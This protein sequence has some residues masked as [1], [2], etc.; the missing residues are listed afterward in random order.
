MA[1]LGFD[2]DIRRAGT[3]MRSGAPWPAPALLR[4][5]HRGPLF[6]AARGTLLT[7]IP[8][9]RAHVRRVHRV[10]AALAACLSAELHK[11][12]IVD[13][14][15]IGLRLKYL[16][17]NPGLDV[18]VVRL[19]R[20]GRGV[21]L[22]YTDSATFA[23]AADPKLRGGGTGDLRR[24]ERLPMADAA[25]EWRRC[26]EEADSLVRR[27]DPSRWIEV[28]Y[29]ELCADPLGTVRA[30]CRFAGVEPDG[31][32]T[33]FRSQEHHVVG[34]GMR[35]D[36]TALIRADERWRD[37]LDEDALRTFQEIAGPMS[38]RLGY[39]AGRTA[40][41]PA[42]RFP[43]R[44]GE[45]LRICIVAHLAY[46]ALA[47]GSAG[48][49]GGVE[50]QTTMLARW[51]VSRGHDVS[52]VTWDEGQPDGQILDGVR[53]L[54]VC[55]QRQGL[56]GV[57]FFHPRWTSLTSALRKANADVY[58]H[59]C[60][61]YVTGQVALWCR[62]NGRAFVFSVASDPECLR[63][64]PTMRSARERLLYRYGLTHADVVIAQT[65]TQQMLLLREFG[66]D[67]SVIPLPCPVPADSG[68][69]RGETPFRVLWLAKTTWD[70]RPDLLLELVKTCPEI[71]FDFAGPIYDDSYSQRVATDLRRCHNVTTHGAVPRERVA[72]LYR[73]AALLCSTSGTEGFPN[74]FLEAWSYGVPVVSTADPDGIVQTHGLGAAC[75]DVGQ[76]AEAIRAF[77]ASPDAL[78]ASSARAREYFLG[79]HGFERVMPRFEEAFAHASRTAPGLR[80]RIAPGVESVA[81]TAR[82]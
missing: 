31:A 75:A 55:A 25:W 57:R 56:R 77:R 36:A 49:I 20:D 65:R 17:R 64:L 47:G 5:L 62:R 7:C 80:G 48:H 24:V 42:A 37:V 14:S 74:T 9:W 78:R 12:V 59:N 81:R 61:E 11:P 21:S 1:A 28:R 33:D 51:L 70:K 4:P 54:K 23:D 10:N 76:L 66:K 45:R 43:R 82:S 15:K 41:S 40:T 58:Y 60:G 38:A 16:L 3:D 19:I 18:K 44:D 26:Q 6:E 39:A 79:H 50:R 53:V 69:P 52:L 29:E 73:A 22:A 67:S 8:G 32:T 34:N 46:G 72:A 68:D 71:E 2:F 27:L 35:L 13:S 63:A 30:I